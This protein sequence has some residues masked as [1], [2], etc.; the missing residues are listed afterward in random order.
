[1]RYVPYSAIYIDLTFSDLFSHFYS[2]FHPSHPPSF[3]L[4]EISSLFLSP[5]PPSLPLSSPKKCVQSDYPPPTG[6]KSLPPAQKQ[7]QAVLTTICVRSSLDLLFQC[8]QLP[9]GSEVLMS[10]MNI[11]DMVK[12][13]RYHGLTPVP[14]D[15]DFKTMNV[16]LDE[17]RN[18][19][20]KTKD[21][22]NRPRVLIMAWVFGSYCNP[23]ELYRLCKQYNIYI[24][25]DMAETFFDINYNGS[26]MADISIFSFGTIKLNTALGGALNIVRGDEAI[27]RKMKGIYESYSYLS[28]S[29]FLKRW[30]KVIPVML[31]LNNTYLNGYG[32][33]IVAKMGI[34]Y[35]EK[36][37]GLVRGF[38]PTDDFLSTFRKKLPTSMLAFLYYRLKS[39]DK[40]AFDQGTKRQETGKNFL[41]EKGVPVPGSH[42]DYK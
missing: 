7:F 1:M 30:I 35:K 25:E 38:H 24:V 23:E 14:V 36:V 4:N 3:Y 19:L 18:Y 21:K 9:L 31:A 34:E 22:A 12:I 40:E 41:V 33:E 6:S 28:T 37:V 11:P 26:P 20:E 5:N 2:T 29:F 15:L 32:R 17:M 8:L 16:K 39:Y 13:V 42:A 27:Y 10:A